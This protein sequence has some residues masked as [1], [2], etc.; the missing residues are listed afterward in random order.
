MRPNEIFETFKRSNDIKGKGKID[1]SQ[2]MDTVEDGLSNNYSPMRTP[3]TWYLDFFV[4]NL[5]ATKE[6]VWALE[7]RSQIESITM[8]RVTEDN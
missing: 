8:K 3:M 5:V 4:N 1:N 2:A 7:E 6:R